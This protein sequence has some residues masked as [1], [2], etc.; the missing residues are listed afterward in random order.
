MKIKIN[1]IEQVS[2]A[3][4]SVTL[5]LGDDD[6]VAHVTEMDDPEI[7]GFNF[8]EDFFSVLFAFDGL[9]GRFSC[10]YWSFRDGTHSIF[11]WDYG[12]HDRGIVERAIEESDTQLASLK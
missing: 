10:D 1:S 3:Q 8:D 4:F 12:V 6:V 9:G 2:T 11:P 7:R 5:T